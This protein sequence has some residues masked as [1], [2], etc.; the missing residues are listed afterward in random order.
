MRRENIRRRAPL[1]LT[2]TLLAAV[3]LTASGCAGGGGQTVSTD[4]KPRTPFEKRAE[5][6]AQDWPEAKPL[7]KRDTSMLPA[8]GARP[9]GDKDAEAVTVTVGHSACDKDFGAHVRESGDLVVV[10]GWAKKEDGVGACTG[11]LIT[12]K[13]KVKL[14]RKLGDRSLVDAA[15]GKVLK[16]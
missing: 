9:A 8:Q 1:A 10:A 5:Q 11:Q 15:T 14:D 4:D 7:K 3:A 12:D 16:G 13:V 2:T 6:L